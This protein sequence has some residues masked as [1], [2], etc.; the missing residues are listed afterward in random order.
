MISKVLPISVTRGVE[1]KS[2]QQ[3]LPR[4]VDP[5]VSLT[6]FTTCSG[7]CFYGC[8]L[9]H[10]TAFFSARGQ[11][12]RR[13][14]PVITSTRG[15]LFLVISIVLIL[16]VKAQLGCPVLKGCTT[17]NSALQPI[18]QLTCRSGNHLSSASR[19]EWVRC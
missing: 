14:T 11:H 16:V 6:M 17:H 5:T 15:A 3:A 12:R 13:S 9:G 2:N 8:S 19:T 10:C 1:Y 4:G 7:H 18:V